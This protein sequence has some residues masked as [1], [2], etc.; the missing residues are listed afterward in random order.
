LEKVANTYDFV[1]VDCGS[2][3]NESQL[4]LFDM[5]TKIVLMATPTL[6][7]IKNARFMLDLFDRLNYVPSKT[8]FV[9]NQVEDERQQRAGRVTIPTETIEKHLKRQ[10]EAKIPYDLRTILSAVNKGVPVITYQRDRTKSPIK[11]MVDFSEHVYNSLMGEQVMDDDSDIERTA[12]KK[13]NPLL[14]LGR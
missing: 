12:I 9:L 4:S 1:V 2:Y 13:K 11:E 8:L 10:V 3:L 14:R 7:S 5:A 6:A